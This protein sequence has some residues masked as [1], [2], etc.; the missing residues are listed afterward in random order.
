MS[1]RSFKQSEIDIKRFKKIKRI[2]KGGFGVVYKVEEKKTGENYAAKVIDCN[3]DEEKCESIINREVSI[4][5]LAKH[6]TIIKFIGYSK[7]DFHDEKNVTIIMELA[8]NGSLRDVLT[9][10]QEHDGP[11]D[12]TNTTRNIFMIVTLSIGILK[13][14]TFYLMST[15]IHILQILASQKFLSTA[16]H[17][18]KP[19]LVVH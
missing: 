7:V 11:K 16:I 14:R 4:M 2:N 12:Y 10:I 13:R 6:P 5:L 18:V 3:D 1:Q 8:Q 15:F 9:K 17:T 19:N